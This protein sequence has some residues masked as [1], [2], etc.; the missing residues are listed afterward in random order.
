[1]GDVTTTDLRIESKATEYTVTAAGLP[2]DDLDAAAF[3]I[4]VAYRGHGLWAVLRRRWCLGADGEWE[5]EPI[6][7]ER[8]AA[9][10][11]AHRFD[12]DT[13]LR[14]AAAEVPH[15]RTNGRTVH[16]AIA[17]AARRQQAGC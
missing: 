2:E 15:L 5:F 12:L 14:L 1:M 4:T 3:T 17:D 10:L 11:A 7:S 16:D 6:P 8:T 13:A 9:W